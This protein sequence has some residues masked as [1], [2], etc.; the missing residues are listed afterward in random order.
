MH[1]YSRIMPYRVG[2]NAPLS[3]YM[4]FNKY[5]SIRQGKFPSGLLVKSSMQAK[6]LLRHYRLLPVPC[7]LPQ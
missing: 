6:R 7:H 1:M 5:L 2:D 4:L 3:S